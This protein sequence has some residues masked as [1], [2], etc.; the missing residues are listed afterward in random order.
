MA[1]EISIIV[2]EVTQIASLEVGES[3][4]S[5]SMCADTYCIYIY[6]CVCVCVFVCIHT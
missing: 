5:T 3:S 4:E 1:A 2:G 6:I